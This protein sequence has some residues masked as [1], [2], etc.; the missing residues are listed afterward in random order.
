MKKILL[1]LNIF[2]VVSF[3]LSEDIIFLNGIFE[4]AYGLENMES[5]IENQ[6]VQVYNEF[7]EKNPAVIAHSQGGVRGLGL[8]SKMSNDE[9]LSTNV[10]ALITI[11]APVKGY[12]PLLVGGEELLNRSKG[13]V[14]DLSDGLEAIGIPSVMGLLPPAVLNYIA[15]DIIHFIGT[16]ASILKDYTLINDVMDGS[17]FEKVGLIDQAPGSQYFNDYIN[18]SHNYS[19]HYELVRREAGL[20]WVGEVRNGVFISYEMSYEYVYVFILDEV[21]TNKISSEVPLGFIVGTQSNPVAGNSFAEDVL[22]LLSDSFDIGAGWHDTQANLTAWQFWNNTSSNHKKSAQACRDAKRLV[23]DP[24][25]ILGDVYGTTS[26][27]LLV[28]VSDQSRTIASIGGK[29]IGNNNVVMK[30]VD[31]N[32]EEELS[33]DKIWGTGEYGKKDGKITYTRLSIIGD[34]LAYQKIF[35]LEGDI[36][37]VE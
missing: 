23:S 1:V 25:K 28:P 9:L 3:A 20:V 7:K 4:E 12:S 11:G 30:E 29:A 19:G 36:V 6:M 17:I 24:K 31:A 14:K 21:I 26:N 22:G 13:V 16:A 8:A 37:G 35:G 10:K 15:L 2:I 18:P 32:H 27:D 5:S 34:W 33:H